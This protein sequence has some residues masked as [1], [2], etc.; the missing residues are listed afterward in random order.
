M[1]QSA[2]Q[3]CREANSPR[4]CPPHLAGSSTIRTD[5]ASPP[6]AHSR[7]APQPAFREWL[8]ARPRPSCCSSWPVLLPFPVLPVVV[9]ALFLSARTNR[10][11]RLPADSQ[12]PVFCLGAWLAHSCSRSFHRLIGP[13][14]LGHSCGCRGGIGL[15]RKVGCDRENSGNR[16]SRTN[17][18]FRFLGTGRPGIIQL[19]V[20]HIDDSRKPA[21]PLEE[22]QHVEVWPVGLRF[23]RHLVVIFLAVDFP[24]RQ[25]TQLH[26]CGARRSLDLPDELIHFLFLRHDGLQGVQLLVQ[27]IH[28]LFRFPI[29]LLVHL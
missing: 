15:F 7:Q 19:Q 17:W 20:S 24:C 2:T 8:L 3:A 23:K 13:G 18:I 25:L 12:L 22:I 11:R 14:S 5:P 29:T 26:V 9:S 27:R 6:F 1:F 4:F 16:R 21:Q 10:F 28:L